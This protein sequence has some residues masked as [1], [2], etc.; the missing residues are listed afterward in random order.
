M[1]TYNDSLVNEAGYQQ[2]LKKK[3]EIMIFVISKILQNIHK[4]VYSNE[5]LGQFGIYSTVQNALLILVCT[6]CCTFSIPGLQ[7]S[8]NDITKILPSGVTKQYCSFI[9]S[10]GSHHN[11]CEAFCLGGKCIRTVCLQTCWVIMPA[12]T[13]EMCEHL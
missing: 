5:Y 7:I 6:N 12:F 13:G 3:W 11:V 8:K 2:V 9:L 4:C 10:L 1:C